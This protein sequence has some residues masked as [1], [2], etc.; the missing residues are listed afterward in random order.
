MTI[1]GACQHYDCP[2]RNNAGHCKVTVCMNEKYNGWCDKEQAIENRRNVNPDEF[3]KAVEQYRK[4]HMTNA[5]RIRSMNDEE[6]AHFMAN[7]EPCRESAWLDWL[8]QEATDD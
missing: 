3:K 1:Y 7:I 2:L 6:L 8:K 5:D 4:H